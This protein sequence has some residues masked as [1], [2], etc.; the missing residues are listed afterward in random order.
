V[1]FLD[2]VGLLPLGIPKRRKRNHEGHDVMKRKIG[3]C[4]VG[5]SFF[6]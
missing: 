2:D 5:V 6:R 4:H 1:D 3:D